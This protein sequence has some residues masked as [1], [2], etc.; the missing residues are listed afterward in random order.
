MPCNNCLKVINQASKLSNYS[1]FSYLDRRAWKG[2]GEPGRTPWN[3]GWAF[4]EE[5]GGGRQR[6]L[7]PLRAA[8][9]GRLPG[10]AH[11][12]ARPAGGVA[13]RSRAPRARGRR[14]RGVCVMAASTLGSA[15][16]PLRLGVPGLC[17]RRPLR[18]LWARAWRL[19][20][21]VASGRSV[22]AASGLGASGT[23]RYCLELL[24]W[25]SPAC[26]EV[27]EQGRKGPSWARQA[28]GPTWP[29]A[30]QRVCP[31]VSPG[32]GVGVKPQELSHRSQDCGKI[33]SFVILLEPYLSF[34]MNS[35][36]K[37]W[38]MTSN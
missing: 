24:R 6:H 21:P 2:R 27:R 17:C 28:S 20:E 36:F 25:E 38:K 26:P 10:A 19:S 34:Y 31:G 32:C 37:M 15:W 22:A 4:P 30:L 16:G 29:L 11:S 1:P 5:R 35:F 33:P 8:A 14:T 13:E 9:G 18:G 23:D 3:S 7:A 12:A